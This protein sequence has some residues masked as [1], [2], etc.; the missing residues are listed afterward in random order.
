MLPS[1]NAP[2]LLAQIKDAQPETPD[3]TRLLRAVLMDSFRSVHHGQTG[4]LAWWH[5]ELSELNEADPDSELGETVQILA[6]GTQ[7][8]E[9]TTWIDDETF[10]STT[11]AGIVAAFARQDTEVLRQAV[12]TIISNTWQATFH[13]HGEVASIL[14]DGLARLGSNSQHP[15]IRRLD[16]VLEAAEMGTGCG[17]F[18]NGILFVCRNTPRAILNALLSNRSG[19]GAKQIPQGPPETGDLELICIFLGRLV[20]AE[21]VHVSNDEEQTLYTLT[22]RGLR[23]LRE[24]GLLTH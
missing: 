3:R 9:T 21:L 17:R 7:V 16:E 15:L 13:W 22:V 18:S 6:L 1:T 12:E 4:L 14:R 20:E 10:R 23:A 11:L 19:V 2:G 24:M 8:T 5:K